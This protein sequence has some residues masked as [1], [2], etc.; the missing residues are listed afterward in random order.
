MMTLAGRY[1]AYYAGGALLLLSGILGYW[2]L[3]TYPASQRTE[4]VFVYATLTN[5]FIRTYA[6]RCFVG[7]EPATLFGYYRDGRTIIASSTAKVH[8]VLI[9]VSPTEL[10]RLDRYE[11]TPQTYRREI[12]SINNQPAFV[13]IKN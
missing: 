8:G 10:A 6:C 11:N 12:I 4:T 9:T 5:P 3:V 7:S 13:Y 2:L 1:R